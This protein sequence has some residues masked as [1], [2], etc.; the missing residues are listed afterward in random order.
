MFVKAVGEEP[1][2]ILLVYPP[3]R[4]FKKELVFDPI[5]SDAPFPPLGLL[6]LSAVLKEAGHTV[7]IFD[8]T[9]QSD[10]RAF[11]RGRKYDLAGV[12]S[13][14]LHYSSLLETCKTL[15]EQGVPVVVGGPFPSCFPDLIQCEDVDFLIAGEG[16]ESL[17]L[18]VDA[19]AR[20]C[21]D[22]VP[23]LAWKEDGHI[24][25]NPVR[26][27]KDVDAL[28]FP[29]RTYPGFQE[30]L[31]TW[32]KN[33]KVVCTS[34]ISSRGCPYTCVFCDKS[35]FGTKY[36]SRSV[37]SII[38][39]LLYLDSMGVD[40]VWFT[41]D[42]F[43]LDRKRVLS[44][45]RKMKEEHLDMVWYCDSRVDTIDEEMVW[46][47]K[48]AGCTWIGFGVESGNPD[49]L[50]YIEKRHTT[51]DVKRAFE[52]CRKAQIK[53]SAYFILGF[54]QDTEQTVEETV[55]FAMALDADGVEFSL[56]IP[57]PGTNMWNAIKK[58]TAG[59]DMFD[60]RSAMVFDH[61]HF[62][63][64]E[65]ETMVQEAYTRFIQF[66]REKDANFSLEDQW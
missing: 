20:T 59:F 2:R 51:D 32:K 22:G 52:I 47:M 10:F 64:R 3:L 65:A 11:V 18:L 58:V 30:Y 44:L 24:R 29:D 53:R 66:K 23:G 38:A 34:V 36:R 16:E 41:D 12:S 26:A 54:P 8:G 6:Y 49:I 25:S 21:Y 39:E 40:N 9:F 62:S 31:R 45:C 33:Y 56:P 13:T 27:I 4:A 48:K 55:Q 43:T 28:P 42:L 19:L 60:N 63:K 50:K 7:T 1:M 61:P 14:V 46:A 57:I 35:V 17:L 15:K 37:E 5:P